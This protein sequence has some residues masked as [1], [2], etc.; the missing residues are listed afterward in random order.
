MVAVLKDFL[1]LKAALEANALGQNSNVLVNQGQGPTVAAVVSPNV[2]SPEARD[3]AASDVVTGTVASTPYSSISIRVFANDDGGLKDVHLINKE[4]NQAIELFEDAGSSSPVKYFDNSVDVPLALGRNTVIVS[5]VNKAGAQTVRTLPV[6][7]TA[8]STRPLGVLAIATTEDAAASLDVKG[9]IEAMN[10]FADVGNGVVVLVGS[11]ATYSRV[12]S[13]ARLIDQAAIPGSG[14]TMIYFGG[15]GIET[16]D[17][18]RLL[19]YD[20]E[21]PFEVT[22]M[23]VNELTLSIT[24][25]I[26]LLDVCIDSL[27][28]TKVAL[29][30]TQLYPNSPGGNSLGGKYRADLIYSVR[31]CATKPSAP[32][33]ARFV[34][35]SASFDLRTVCVSTE[36]F[37]ASVNDGSIIHTLRATDSSEAQCI[38]SKH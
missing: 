3:I 37:V 19:P 35:T 38:G 27:D 33:A 22:G 9:M 24:P 8:S 36:Q 10:R 2:V 5:G 26:A 1:R 32:L 20:A 16:P 11:D 31:D 17:G 25:R 34:A 6:D 15:K 30:P 18:L 29:L 13:V 21:P 7:R 28:K 23:P 14:S 4:T 12:L